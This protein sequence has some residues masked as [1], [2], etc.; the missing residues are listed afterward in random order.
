[1]FRKQILETEGKYYIFHTNS[2][3]IAL[4]D[5]IL[6]L[7]QSNIS[8]KRSFEKDYYCQKDLLKNIDNLPQILRFEIRINS[9]KYLKRNFKQQIK[10]NY[11]I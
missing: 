10:L 9:A 3:D 7:K 11:R 6:D 1:M 2:V 5:K 8:E 4:Y